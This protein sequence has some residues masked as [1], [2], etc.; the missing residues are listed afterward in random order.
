MEKLLEELQTAHI[1]GRGYSC[2]RTDD[3]PPVNWKAETREVKSML[4]T[5]TILYHGKCRDLTIIPVDNVTRLNAV[6]KE[7][8]DAMN[9]KLEHYNRFCQWV[10]LVEA[11]NDHDT[12]ALIMALLQT[13]ATEMGLY[14]AKEMKMNMRNP[15]ACYSMMLLPRQPAE[16]Q[17]DKSEE[18]REKLATG[19]TTS[20]QKE[21]GVLGKAIHNLH[22]QHHNYT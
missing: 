19:V 22:S 18:T 17:G 20:Q 2:I 12:N 6:T 9:A 16:M 14:L 13:D 21:G 1:H 11:A 10:L 7:V 5:E 4:D 15:V 8:S 3:G